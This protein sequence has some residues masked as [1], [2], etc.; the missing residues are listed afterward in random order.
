MTAMESEYSH[1]FDR[2]ADS[3]C[4]ESLEQRNALRAL[5]ELP[6]LTAVRRLANDG[7]FDRS[8]LRDDLQQVCAAAKLAGVRAEQVL[9]AVKEIWAGLPVARD[10]ERSPIAKPFISQVVTMTL[11]EYYETPN[12]GSAP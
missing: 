5:L 1:S 12:R 10:L 4:T 8:A 11:D 6:L 9:I 7:D 3:E 2:Q